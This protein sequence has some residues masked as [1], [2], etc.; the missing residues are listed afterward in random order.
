MTMLVGLRDKIV[1]E[2]VE[3]DKQKHGPSVLIVT[4]AESIDDVRR[5][6]VVS[7]GDGFVTPDGEQIPLSLHV[8]DLVIF[9][10]NAGKAVWSYGTKYIILREQE[11]LATESSRG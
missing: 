2:P 7:V 9:P 3:T 4:T 5:G 11:V 6:R 1:V 10:Q 8:G